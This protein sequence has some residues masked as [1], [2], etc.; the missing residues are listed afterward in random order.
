MKSAMFQKMSCLLGAGA[1]ALICLPAHA[2]IGP[3]VTADGTPFVYAPMEPIVVAD[4]SDLLTVQLPGI[5][6]YILPVPEGSPLEGVLVIPTINGVPLPAN[7]NA[8]IA[9]AMYDDFT[10]TGRPDI[11][12]DVFGVIST[13]PGAPP[14]FA[15]ISDRDTLPL[16]MPP[17]FGPAPFP[18][19]ETEAALPLVDPVGVPYI[20]GQG[21]FS[22]DVPDRAATSMLLGLG[23]TALAALRRKLA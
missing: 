2:T 9:T 19:L 20:F 3:Q 5:G 13:V 22:S 15:F 6:P 21:S 11:L 17:D 7:P 18:V 10:S 1:V 16:A 12:S 4:P 8:A 23:C 14:V